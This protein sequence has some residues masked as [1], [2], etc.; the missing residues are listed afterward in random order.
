MFNTQTFRSRTNAVTRTWAA[1]VKAAGG[2]FES[3]SLSIANSFVSA[4]RSK[5]YYT[6]LIYLLPMLG[7]GINAARV[8]LIDRLNIGAATNNNFVDAD[9]TQSTGLKGNGTNKYLNSL[10]FPSQLGGGTSN[11]GLGFWENLYPA[12]PTTTDLMGCYNNAG[13]GRFVLDIRT[14]VSIIF[15]S[16]GANN[17]NVNRTG[18]GGHYYGNRS[19]ATSRQLFL[20]GASIAT[21]STSDVPPGMSDRVMWILGSDESGVLT[22]WSGRCALAYMTDGTMTVDE[23]ADFHAVLRNYL[24]VPTGK[25]QT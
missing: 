13:T 5:S 20:N 18:T 21:N 8:P 12:S 17:A 4:L 23:T 19:S 3:D 14:T 11:G 16:A 15:W 25:P 1:N 9:F 24:M 2:G 6:R 7:K 22:Y 10:I